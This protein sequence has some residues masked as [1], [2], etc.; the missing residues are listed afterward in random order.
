MRTVRIILP[1]MAAALIWLLP[2]TFG[3]RAAE[4]PPAPAAN[5]PAPAAPAPAPAA[6]PAAK[7][8]AP[9]APAKGEAAPA[10]PAPAEKPAEKAAEKPAEKPAASAPPPAAAPAAAKDVA[11]TA[12]KPEAAPAAPVFEI[13]APSKDEFR[14][15]FDGVP[16]GDVIQRFAQMAGKPLLGDSKVVEGSLTFF[17]S[18]PYTFDEAFDMLNLLLAMKGFTLIETSRYCQVVPLQTATKAPLK[19]LRGLDAATEVRAGEV[20]TMLLPLK[21]LTAED[22]VKVLQPVVSIFGTI[23]P[24]GRGRGIIIT[25]RLENIRR[26]RVILDEMDTSTLAPPGERS[27]KTYTLKNASAR[28]ISTII[29][30]VFGSG[31]LGGAGAGGIPRYIRNPENG[32][33]MRNPEWNPEAAAKAGAAPDI[34]VKCSADERTNTLFVT[35]PPDKLAMAEEL[36]LK[37]DQIRP[38]QTGDMRIFELKNAKAEDVAST[39]RQILTGASRGPGEGPRYGEGRFGSQGASAGLQTRVVAD[40]G[41]NRLIVTAPLDQMNRI[42]ELI[43]QLDQANLK[44][45]G[46]IRV[47][48]LKVADAQQ[49]AGVLAN[50]LRKAGVQDMSGHGYPQP[51][52][53]TAQV[54]ADTRTNSLIVAGSASDIQTADTLIKEL[55]RPLEK[56]AR[57]IHVVQLKA[58][59]A[60]QVATALMQLLRQA[61]EGGEG[62]FRRYGAPVASNVR[63]EAEPATNSLLISAAPGDWE[64]IKKILDQIETSVVPQMTASTRLLPLK[65]AK[66][67]SLAETLNQ[68]YSR[69][70]RPSGGYGSYGGEYSRPSN[71]PQVPVVIAADERSNTLI[72]SA[73]EDDQ[74]S[75]ADLIKTM[76]VPG[77][78]TAEQIRVI[79]L[80]AGDATKIAENI[81]GLYQTTGGY[82]ESRAARNVQIFIQGDPASNSLLVRA[83]DTEF[84]IIEKLVA[85]LDTAITQSGGIKTFRLKVADAQQLATVLQGALAKR[86]GYSRWG[87]Q[88]A[89]QTS[90]SADVRTNSVIVA[91]PAADIQTA[92]TLIQELDKPLD[93]SSREIHVVQLKAGDARQM[94]TALTNL[95]KQGETTGRWGASVSTNNIRIEAETATNSLL[96]SA[97][98]GDWPTIQKILDQLSESASPLTVAATRLIALK[99]AKA[100]EVAETLRQ[101]FSSTSS[102]RSYGS[103]YGSGYGRRYGGYDGY[104]SESS[105][106]TTT[107]S[108]VPVVIAASDSNNSLIVT[109]SEEDHK[110]I[111]QLVKEMDVAQADG[112]GGVRLIQ[113]KSADASKL[114]ETL[115]AMIPPTTRLQQQSIFIQADPASNTLLLRAPEAD[116]KMFEE[117]I[118]SLDKAS[119]EGAREIRLIALKNISAATLAQ[120]LTQL[121]PSGGSQASYSGYSGYRRY[122]AASTSE[123][124]D[125]VTIAA[126]P[127]DRAI[128]VD[129]PREKIEEIVRL[130]TTLDVP[131][132]AGETQVRTYRLV[133]AKAAD[134]ASALSRLFEQRYRPGRG[135]SETEIQPRFEADTATNHVIVA[136]TA[137]QFETIEKL[138]K[139]LES[140]TSLARETKTF[141]LKFAKAVEIVEVL[142]TMLAE[143]PS[144]GGGGGRYGYRSETS[145]VPETRVAAIAETNDIVVQGTPEKITLADQLIKTFDAQGAEGHT[146]IQIV[147]LKNAQAV[148]LAESI[149]ATLAENATPVSFGPRRGARG[150]FGGGSAA[151]QNDRVIVTPET[152]S[153]SVLVRGPAAD[154]PT[155]VEMIKKLDDGS[156][157]GG[158]QVRV[159]PLQN[160]EP[161]E[162]AASLGK[163][164]QEMIR[165]QTGGMRGSGQAIP[166]SIAADER[167]RSIVVTTTPG[168]FALIEQVLRQLDQAEGAP[169][170]DVQYIWLENA[171]AT[172][173]ASKLGDLYSARK[174]LDKPVISADSFSN[175]VTIIA[176][177]ADLKAMEPI[178]QKLDDAAKDNN[179]RVRV[180]PLTQ[181]KAEKMAEVLKA[182]YLQMTGNEVKV[183]AEPSSTTPGAS[184]ATPI[185]ELSKPGLTPPPAKP[186]ATPA[187]AAPEPKE[188]A[189]A[190]EKTPR[191]KTRGEGKKGAPED[192]APSVFFF[193]AP[194]PAPK[195]GISIGVDKG[196]N[197][198]IITGKRQDLD[199]LESLVNQL[200]PSSSSTEAEYRVFK[201]EKADPG[202]VARTLDSLFNPRVMIM[203]QMQQMQQAG[204]GQGG[205][206][207]GGGG[208]GQQQAAP[209]QAPPPSIIVVADVRTSSVIIR[210]KPMEFEL[211]EPLVKHL[212]QIPT[213]ASEIRIF[214]LKNTDANDVAANLKDLFGLN[215]RQQPGQP[216][217]P[218]PQP[219]Q[220]PQ[221]GQQQRQA[222]IRQMM[223]LANGGGTTQIDSNTM[224]S[225]TANRQTNSVVVA[226]PNDVM[227]IVERVIQELDQ[228]GV[229]SAASVRL[230]PIKNA[231]VRGL[232]SALQ[233]IFVTGATRQS[234]GFGGGRGGFGQGAAT[235]TSATETPIVVTGNEAGRLV[236]V[237]APTE[238]HEVI[239]KVIKEMDDAEGVG[240]FAIKV[241]H[242]ENADATTVAPALSAAIDRTGGTGGRGM[243]GQGGGAGQT[244]ISADRSSN[245]IVVRAAAQ[246]HEKIAQLISELDA[247]VTTVVRMYPLKNAEV[248]STVTA[249][250]EI[251]S[252]GG[253]VATA[254]GRR[255]GGAGQAASA[256]RGTI[257][258]SGDDAGRLVIV[259]A[260]ESKHELVAK[261]IKEID[262]A[263][264]A[265]DM[266][267][268]VYRLANA[269]ATTM[270]TAL[271]GTVDRGGQSMGGGGRGGQGRAGDAS[272]AI[273]ISADRGSNSLV[274]RASAENHDK[275]AKLITEMD[276]SPTEQ[277][278]VRLIPLNNADAVSVAQV[279]TRVFGSG[280]AMQVAG[281][282]GARG[283]GGA[284]QVGGRSSVMIEGDRDARMLMVR[285]DEPTFEKV[286]TLAQQLDIASQGGESATTVIAMKFA[287]ASAVA[288]VLSQAFGLPVRAG[289]AGG[290]GGAQTA[291]VNPDDIVTILAEPTT[292]S[293]L[294]TANA[295]NLEKV[296]ALLAKLDTE[297]AGG[298]RTEMLILKNARSTE[299]APILQRMVQE[300]PLGASGA[301]GARGGA[302]AGGAGSAA[303]VVVSADAGSNAL[304][305]TGPSAQIDKVLKTA[306][307][308]DQATSEPLVKMYPLKN[309]EVK[310]TVTA[311]QDLFGTGSTP[312][313]A[314]GGGRRG[315]GAGS[316]AGGV[317]GSVV[318]TGDE[319]GRTVVVSAPASKHELIAKVIKD[320]DEA[321][322]AS[323]VTIKVYRLENS[324]ATTMATALQSTVE[325]GATAGGGG[326]GG[327]AAAGAAAGGAVRISADRGSNSL[328]V[329]ASAQDHEKIAQLISEMDVSPT[330]QFAVRLIPLNN[331]DATNV[332]QVLS[333]IFTNTAPTQAR[334][335]QGARGAVGATAALRQPIVIEADRNARMLMVRADDPTFEKIRILAQQLD[336]ASTGAL[337]T[338]V[339]A[340]KFAQAASVGPAISQAFGGA[341]RFGFGGRGGAGGGMPSINP[342]DMVTVVAEPMSNSLLVTANAMNL[343]KVKGLLTKLD[344]EVAGGIRTELLLLKN[345][346]A[347]DLAPTLSRMAQTSSTAP[348]GG[349]GRF[350]AMMGMAGAAAAP[351][352][353]VVSADVGS[354]GLVVS[355][356]SA[357]VDKVLK[358]ARDLDQATGEPL[359][360]TYPIKN[361]DVRSVVTA[362][363]ELT[364]SG[365]RGGT[366][367]G[368]RRFQAAAGTTGAGSAGDVVVSGDEVG[369]QVI[370]SAPKEKHELV[371]K[372][373][374]EM[375]QAAGSDSLTAKIYRL[376]NADATTVGP[377]LQAALEK[378]APTGA[379]GGMRSTQAGTQVRINADR[380]SNTLVVRASTEDHDR[381]TKL[382]TEMD[383]APSE[384]YAVRLIPLNTAD[385][386]NVATVLTRLFTG[387]AA[388][389]AAGIGARGA[390]TGPRPPVIIEADRDARMLM[391][392][393]D[394]PTF[395]K[396]RALA[397]KMDESSKGQ[398]APTVIALKFAKADG[399]AP[400]LAAAFAP[401]AGAGGRA[402]A[403]A[404]PDD[405]VTVVAEPMSNSLIVTANSLNL[406]KV[407]ALL[408]QLD[409][410]T[411]GGLRTELRI[412]KNAKA[413]DVA[414]VL[415]R[416]VAAG[417]A[418]GRAA[419][420]SVTISADVGSN[421]IVVSGPSTEIEKVLKMVQEIDDATSSTVSSVYVVALK[422]GDATTVAQMVRDL[423]AQQ[424]QSALRD[425]KSIDPLA[426]SSDTRSNAIVLATTKQMYEQVTEW[427]TQIEGMAPSRGAVRIITL[428][429]ADPAELDKAIKQ[430]FGP[431]GGPGSTT[432]PVR[433][434]PG[435][436]AGPIGPSGAP[437]A[438]GT[439]SS[440]GKVD[441]TVLPAQKSVLVNA[442]D[443][444]FETIRKLAEALDAAA[445]E[446]RRQVKV[447]SLKNA[448]N[449]RVAQ[450]LTAMYRTAATVRPGVTAAPEDL[451][452][453]T[454]LPDTNAVVVSTSKVKMEEVEHLIAELDKVEIAPQLEF[455]IYPLKNVQPT[456][457]MPL[458]TQM[459]AQVRQLRPDEPISVQADERTRSVIVTARGPM[460][461]QVGKIVET[462]DKEPEHATVEVLIIPLK[463][464]DAP[465]LATV[466][467][468]MLRP[469]G[470]TQVTPEARALQ[471][472][473]RLLRVSGPDGAK[474]PELDLTKPIKVSADPGTAGGAGGAAGGAAAGQG[475]NSLIITSTP[476]NLKA[477][478][479]IVEILDTV[480]IAEGTKVRILHLENADAAAV[481]TVLK[482]IFTQGKTLAG[483]VGTSVA[484][485]AE[486]ESTSGKALV[487]ALN[488]S[489]DERTNTLVLSGIEESLALAEAVAKDL[490]RD[491]GKIVTEVR[492]FRLKFAD[493]T[494][495]QP[496]LQA[497]FAEST[498]G[499]GGGAATAGVE[500]VRTQVTRLRTIMDKQA[501]HTTEIP[502][503]RAALTIQADATTSIVIVAARSDMMPLI[504]DVINTMDVAGAGSMNAVRIY[505]LANSD[506]TRLKTVIDGLYTG[507]SAQ[508]VRPE[509]KPVVQVDIRTNALVVSTSD[510]TF[511]MLDT[512]LKSL[513][514]KQPIEMRDVRLIPL[515]NADAGALAPILQ[516]M[517]DARVQRVATL[518]Q[519]DA[520]ALR[521]IIT[522]DVRS[523]SL[524]VGGS[525]EGFE[526]VKSL[527]QQLDDAGP[528]IVGQIKLLPLKF[529]NAGI[530]STTLS[531]LFTQRYAAARTPDIARQKPVV[532]ADTRVNALLVAANADDTK[533]IE[534]L[535]KRMD[536]ELDPSVQL[537]LLPLKFNDAGIVGPEIQRLFAARLTS[538]TPPG[539]APNPQ[540]RVDIGT[541]ALSNSLIISASKENLTLIKG[542]LEKVDVEPPAE[543]GIVR[544]YALQNSDATRIATLLQG[545]ISQGLYK[546]GVAMA[547]QNSLLAAREKV[548]I[549][550]DVRTNVLIVSASKE[551]FAVIDEI[552]KKI[553]STDDFGLLGDVRIFI[554]KNAT[555]TRLA[556]TL[557]QLFTAKRTAEQQAGGTGR[558]LPVSVFAD[559]RT[560]A[561]LV[562]GSKES[563]NALEAMIRELDTDQVLAANEFRVFYLKQAT[564]QVLAPTLTQLFA[565]RVSRGVPLDPV[566]VV[567][568]Q[569]TNSLIVAASP[570]DMKLAES[571]IGR[572]D[573]EP[574]RPGTTV[575]VFAL[576]KADATQ[577]STTINNLYKSAPGGAGAGAT[578]GPQV[579]VS[580]DERI[581]ALIVSA[582]PADQKRI[583]ELVHQ[584]DT[585]SVPRVTEIRVFTL[586]NAD[587]TELATLL[588][589][590]LNNKPVPLTATSPNRQT[591]LQFIT[592]TKEGGQLTASALQEGVMITP[593][594][595]T[596]SL[597]ISAP[598]ENMSLLESL[599]KAMDSTTP[600]MAE[601]KVFQLQNADARQMSTVLLQLF[602]MQTATGGA[603]AA[604]G[605][606]AIQYTLKTPAETDKG[607]TATMGSAE[608]AAL[609][610]TVDIRTNSLLV[611]GTKRYV[612]L[613]SKVIEDL[614]ASAAEERLTE[615]Y[616][617]RN[618]QAADIQTAVSSFLNQERQLMTQALGTG[619]G[620][621]NYILDREVAIVAEPM[622]NTLLL[623]ASP[624]YFDVIAQ[625]IAELDQP[626]A[627]VLVQ[628][629]LAEVAIDDSTDFGMDWNFKRKFGDSTVSTG[630]NFAVAANLT[631]GFSVSVTGGDLSF[632]LRALQAQSRLEVL[633][634]PQIM[635]SDN[636][637]ATI[638]IGQR[639]PFI[640]NSRVTEN[641]TTLNTVQYQQIGIILNVIP[642]IN[643]DG[644]VK[645]T[646][647]PEISSLDRANDIEISPGV[648]AIVINSRSA[649][650]TVTVQDGH[651]IVIGGLI[652]TS[653]QT[654]EDKV[655]ILGDIPILGWLFRSTHV[656]KERTELLIILTP[657]VIRNAQEADATSQSQVRR[658]NL[659]RE[660]K[661]DTMQKALFKSLDPETG[662]KPENGGL[663]PLVVEPAKTPTKAPAAPLTP[664]APS[665]AALEPATSGA[666]AVK[667]KEEMK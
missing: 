305:I 409:T 535:L 384:Q 9:A 461:D 514:A 204:G 145:S 235:R 227:T 20:V 330:D 341:M 292:N 120:M 68:I 273:R 408:A 548:A 39:L 57:E 639:V 101:V 473:I 557:Q 383:M 506:A 449:T 71:A 488:V 394:D 184:G 11:A 318:I 158:A 638:N 573:A 464:A 543:T 255:G 319:A 284:A 232:V 510:K 143:A 324:D 359:V 594:K 601:I 606:Q 589:A 258:I 309:A 583:S 239:A 219:G 230:Y 278:A 427:V 516:S 165:Q 420:G 180:I 166:F 89:Q 55:D 429:N 293:L 160:S 653:D 405:I 609:S 310:A 45:V 451:V 657:T 263:Q 662:G 298:L 167:T 146:V 209:A 490:D 401:R 522:A 26:I 111:A 44:Y 93:E 454:A 302:A 624:R 308:L 240:D 326:R 262:D 115:K 607:P 123:T 497:V 312:T 530:I 448:S 122:G 129:A 562:T 434:G 58:G 496:V 153:N 395:E 481:S 290:R 264:G 413:N 642:R 329:R 455:R 19:I 403:P 25:D 83:P 168:Y 107:H 87:A 468:E 487:N 659:L 500:G 398:A 424:A 599:V 142:Q 31:G 321:Q 177:D 128:I 565:Q 98:P 241:Y 422:N 540:D 286:K 439:T 224:I 72:V 339:I 596:N 667:P 349:G 477:M 518:G 375:D 545:L 85:D 574:D 200:T 333:R 12:A 460:F 228:S 560:N 615:I 125:R 171:D 138:I 42:E 133:N 553:D 643:P 276:V 193:K 433:R 21:F 360:K 173:V 432:I 283:A 346:K 291:A 103:G 244:R 366:A 442:S 113:L 445:A 544:M 373:I 411:A 7:D 478:K 663:I 187:P 491:S 637:K 217:P 578:G 337:T 519:A 558:M 121:Y 559:A 331:A 376:S 70:G 404:N 465:R 233:D 447:V 154:V 591:L 96:I 533:V 294:V 78:E 641:G 365:S 124:A 225:V 40:P 627:Q 92:E 612:D 15:Q 526:L 524:M 253:R 603:A 82:G 243:R 579:V 623:S 453:V 564:A 626:P 441:T 628:V 387:A 296:Q 280:T 13:K 84:K 35:G 636:Q 640:T 300:G 586:E 474:I 6:A 539:A 207:R 598:Q 247:T 486:P 313:A 109:A 374:K 242:L 483:K 161:A 64:T 75:I 299:V 475:S 3:L 189:S 105:S 281:G 456:K 116:R 495:L 347:A 100:S 51:T 60:R 656:S 210:A 246:D 556:P 279:L 198:L 17:D 604:T 602:R 332:A 555:A 14:F 613:A 327:M 647:A 249:L 191:E 507:P 212:D 272:G 139:E 74:K 260:P 443:E 334:G 203:Q 37:L 576:V 570:E 378:A 162:L 362:L 33:F 28:D 561:L 95:L 566:T 372:I 194:P 633:S 306:R 661:H 170:A 46:G 169:T 480:P 343:E 325:R 18:K 156:T 295:K 231:E 79:R 546:P 527:A 521:M 504:A 645:L 176:K 316:V 402:G 53:G 269:D 577:V 551:N 208:G 550:A 588:T 226:A 440:S 377:A 390:G 24:L 646:V 590:S 363:Q 106:S 256:D 323:D 91:G 271:Q 649:E 66:A 222:M 80:K 386:T 651:T 199:Y 73:A 190:R 23:A 436:E 112:I 69:R 38:E 61:Q 234:A 452:T 259:S 223:E 542:L 220:G 86:E 485:K 396:I 216:M 163:L 59:D 632:F 340:L 534:G 214:T 364:A 282:R 303:S 315:A 4:S 587:A 229:T 505:P 102:T 541:D 655:P 650:T 482:D 117:M 580:V 48:P 563:F 547:A 444:D 274:V 261:V 523:N 552:I 502:K 419:P 629:L 144:S 52:T 446:A 572:L 137:P 351:G 511:A 155:V 515:K 10:P 131:G 357:D 147:Q 406:G 130:V 585:D 476:E 415:Q 525:A 108:T 159:F 356:P 254:G 251:F 345:A 307:D 27:L 431:G 620:V 56:D 498:G 385:A 382:L 611:G 218:Q 88:P 423:Y 62:G 50:A 528:A 317:A 304:V 418:T 110:T 186:S 183:T 631:P 463:K 348:G 245:S 532:L 1:I 149:N 267:I 618:A 660:S 610:V 288:P 354:N 195:P 412:L 648:K 517:M 47:F 118:A 493:V 213:V 414:P 608:E 369:R 335:P 97:A 320:L 391:V 529:A 314:G 211:I 472:Q 581:N 410:Q 164:F 597:V 358:M 32:E 600:R 350:G 430:I 371:E 311:L 81:R 416:M 2:A 250:Q 76:D 619:Q 77:A 185:P 621:S 179:F 367:G 537:V 393:A 438:S 192:E 479:A 344:T 16:Y 499:A 289:G 635:A 30:N 104:S 450:A 277:Y 201:I 549:T 520:E 150:A 301:R 182:V 654:T 634:R 336:T 370:V 188:K 569:R 466:L 178:I 462:L 652:T 554:L 426:V 508:L 202:S 389:G 8:A 379:A 407:N 666:G 658:L 425:K 29:N 174:G 141:R 536:V 43:K 381:V 484:G 206:R 421:G 437:G 614:D 221:S 54:S 665:K 205:G 512:L 361:A 399:V 617:L 428:Q 257:T 197:S 538:M 287:Q 392:R 252:S 380:S 67:A 501:G 664:A 49:L 5:P 151:G 467:N 492:L 134:L 458:L 469:S 470:A 270:A 489:A 592:R 322:G 457:I 275:I 238:K 90:V 99:H 388:T 135:A 593:D 22:A 568:E 236:I 630:T 36:I 126:A 34:S 595:R 132:G 352:A 397:E 342:D 65:Y 297:V 644:F 503:T 531:T 175:A 119:T 237:S 605:K 417:G 148:T 266:S 616:R 152:N 181:V 625:M 567:I 268:K 353:V 513:D 400:T 41:T 215:Q 368:M 285:A 172:E 248:R 127:G 63:V 459:L 328:V 471:E 114:A 584:L 494:R 140:G 136:A 582:G 622:T 157:S 509:D 571:L 355:G 338:T 575:Q 265:G 94:A 435:G 196:S